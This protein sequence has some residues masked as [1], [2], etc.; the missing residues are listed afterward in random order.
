MHRTAQPR[1]KG[2]AKIEGQIDWGDGPRT[3]KTVLTTLILA[4]GG[5]LVI[6]PG[7]TVDDAEVEYM[8][9]Q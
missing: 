5:A 3:F 4:P 7:A 1:R 9:A 6:K 2:A 8:P